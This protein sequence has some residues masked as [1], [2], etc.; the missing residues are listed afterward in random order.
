MLTLNVGML[1]VSVSYWLL[2]LVNIKKQL[3]L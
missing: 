2:Y 1:N 3:I